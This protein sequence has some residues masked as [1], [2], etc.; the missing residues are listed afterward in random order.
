MPAATI[1]TRRRRVAVRSRARSRCCSRSSRSWSPACSGGSTAQFYVSLDQTDTAAA[2]ALARVRAEQR[3]LQDGLKD[4][5]DDVDYAAAAQRE[6]RRPRR[7]VAGTLRRARASGST[8]C[9]AARSMRA[10]TLL[11][12]EAEYYL[13]VAN[14]ELDLAGDC[15]SAVTALELADSRLA[16]IAN[17]E[18][19]PVR[20]AIAGELLALRSLRLPDI[21]GHRLQPRPPRRARRRVAAARGLAAQPRSETRRASS[22]PRSPASGGCGSR[23]SARCSTSCASSGATSRSRKRCRPPSARSAAGSSRSSSSSRASP[24]CAATSRRFVSGLEMAIAILRRDFDVDSARGRRRAR[25]AA[26]AAQLRHRPAA[27]RHQ[28]LAESVARHSQPEIAECVSASGR[29]SR[30]CSARFAAHFVL[31]DRGYVLVNFRSYV[32][33]MSVPGLVLVLVGAISLRARRSS[34]SRVRR[35]AWR[36][37]IRER[38]LE[39]RGSDLTRASDPPHRRRLGRAAS[40]LL[41]HGLKTPTRRSL[42]YLLAAHAAQLQAPP[43]GATSGSSSPTRI[44]RTARRSGAA[45]ASGAAAT[46]ASSMPRSRRCNASSS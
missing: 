9:R 14:T 7:R 6:P 11:R 36:K 44:P 30:S 24:R 31:A 43:S 29:C 37:A 46:A 32:V 40:G 22:T 34:R 41:T 27:A 8:R 21:E 17:P 2:Q 45:H 38:G 35:S 16:E 3:A 19:G 28:R 5:N 15:D 18:L 20:E 42:N 12:S 33:E 10:A 39:R 1:R 13:T 4:V 23:S 25:A 26:R